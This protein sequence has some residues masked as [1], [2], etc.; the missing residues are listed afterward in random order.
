MGSIKL[1]IYSDGS[2]QAETLGIKGKKCKDYRKLIEEITNATIVEEEVTKEY[3]EEIT[4]D[5]HMLDY[6]MQKEMD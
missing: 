1:R 6:A 5:E 3:Y 2:I 4:V